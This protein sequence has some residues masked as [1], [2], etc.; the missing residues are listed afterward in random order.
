[1]SQIR[2]KQVE[3]SKRSLAAKLFRALLF[4][5]FL[6]LIAYFVVSSGWFVER[7]VVPR[8]GKALHSTLTVGKAEFSP[9][10]QLTLN[11]V[12]LTPDGAET[13]F[14]ARQVHARY[15]LLALVRGNIV[16]ED[17]L[18]DSPTINIVE[19]AQGG[20]NTDGLVP[21]STQPKPPAKSGGKPPQVTLKSLTLRNAT[22][23]HTKISKEGGKTLTE[24]ANANLSIKNVRNGG[25]GTLTFSTALAMEQAVGTPSVAKLPCLL[26]SDLSFALQDNLQ[27]ASLKGTASFSVGKATGEFAELGGLIGKLDCDMT[28]SEVKQLALQFNKGTASLG[29]VRLTGPFDAAKIEGKLKL[30]VTSFD[31][32]VLNLFGAA[33]GIDFGTTTINDT[34]DITI[35]QTG[36]MISLAGRLDIARLQTIQRN[37][38]SPMVDLNCT[39]DV[40]F[41][42]AAKSL[43]LK[44]VNLNGTQNQQPLMSATLSNPLTLAFGDT[45]N[46]ADASLDFALINLNLADWR[47]FAPGLDLAG[48]ANAKGKLFSKDG[49]KRLS[50]E[51][52]K[53]I[54][55]FSAKLGN[56]PTAID[57]ISF[58]GVINHSGQGDSIN[59]KLALN[60]IK[61]A[62][63][64]GAPLE[65]AMGVDASVSNKVANL[66]QCSLKLT[67]TPRAKNEANLTGVV[68]LNEA[69]AITGNLKLAAES[70][71]V[72]SY[73]DLFANKPESTTT[74]TNIPPAKT[75]A[76]G[77]QQEPAPVKLP[78]SNFTVDATIGRL[79]LREIDAANVQASLLLDGSHVLLKPFQLTLNNAPVSAT[80]DLDLSVPGY[81]YNVAFNADGVPVA[82]L[83]NTFSPRYQGRAQGTLIAK[84]DIQGAGVT[85]RNLRTNLN[86][87]I[88]FSFTNANIQI[89]GPMLQTVVAGVA[90]TLQTPELLRSPLEYVNSNLRAGDGK[91]DVA[92]FV[93]QSPAL[94][95]NSA[96]S[97]QIADDLQNSRLSLPVDIAL[98]AEYARKIKLS[99]TDTNDY[100]ALPRFISLIGTL[101][102][103]DRKIEG[104]ALAGTA[105]ST[106]LNNLDTE[107]AGKLGDAARAIGNLLGNKPTTNAAPEAGS[108]NNVATNAPPKTNPLQDLL[109]RQLK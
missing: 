11:Q 43:L 55:N 5:I 57:E 68:D 31:R 23:R 26:N 99:N 47:A 96:G 89:V 66:Q 94:R 46:A 27:P 70:L 71:D 39:Y 80:A 32:Q 33:K 29:R 19:D 103:P 44:A 90:L 53:S 28:P 13:L 9:F 65:L 106:L 35:A 3:T 58:N 18:L 92:Q 12:K 85:G 62:G 104:K 49:G 102:K 107:K 76:P 7:V 15:N 93:A 25:T 75:P 64:T 87:A 34:T 37:V 81:K 97:I 30:E 24:L 78:L 109:R 21:K 56:G 100:V 69:D 51:I 50:I 86:G 20:K 74:A 41:D 91:I 98:A 88:D 105:V 48:V 1:M 108:T 40:T 38:T 52:D 42:S 60:G 45:V 83:A 101:E 59:S 4:L 17:V 67:P 22:L 77:P 8:V 84:V 73:Y 2:L 16:V 95:L 54:K 72:T 36:R 61:L 6:L 63:V 10:T 79:Y 82:P 14:D